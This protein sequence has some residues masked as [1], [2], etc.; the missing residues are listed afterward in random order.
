MGS[1]QW[2]G[3]I[4][5]RVYRVTGGRLGGR[6][7][8]LS[9][10]LLTTTGRKSGEPRTTPLTCMAD[11][12]DWVIVASNNGSDLEPAWWLNLKAQPRAEVQV[13]GDRWIAEARQADAGERERLWPQLVDYNPPYGVYETRTSRQIPVVILRR[14]EQP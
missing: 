2:F 4:H 11:A 14:V 10:L 7:A 1:W 6:L 8:G 12:D 3:R 5:R 13:M 9:M